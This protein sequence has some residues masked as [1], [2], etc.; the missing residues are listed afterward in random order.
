VSHVNRN[1][2]PLLA[3][4][5]AI[6]LPAA[7]PVFAMEV[8]AE[9]DPEGKFGAY[10]IFAWSGKPPEAATDPNGLR[11]LVDRTVRVAAEADLRSKGLALAQDAEPDLWITYAAFVEPASGESI[12]RG[13]GVFEGW[14]LRRAEVYSEGNLVIEFIDRAT[15]KPVWRGWAKGGIDKDNLEKKAREAVR[16]ILAH[17]LPS[18]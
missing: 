5:L 17:Y 3:A 8:G 13:V 2:V 15:G 14:E 4:A 9:H 11:R 10:R 12:H 7:W 16:R 1:A 18:R 6:A